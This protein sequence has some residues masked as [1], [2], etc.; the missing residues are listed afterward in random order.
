RQFRVLEKHLAALGFD[1]ARKNDPDRDLDILDPNAERFTGTI[2]SARALEVLNDPRVQNILFA[3]VGYTFPE[4]REKGV[5]IRVTLTG[6]RLPSVQQ[7]LHAQV[8]AQLEKLGF[9]EALGYDTR[10][11]TQLKGTIPYK[12]LDRLVKDLRG[13]PAGWFLP[14]TPPDRLPR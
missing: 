13:E 14:E 1:D 7:T 9:R 4:D 2:P 5:P 3:P 10:G 11:Y 6:E 12:N 8:W